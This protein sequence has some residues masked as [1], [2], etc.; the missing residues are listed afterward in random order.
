[1]TMETEKSHSL[2]SASW[3]P[4][5]VDGALLVQS[6]MPKN[7][8]E[9]MVQVQVESKG[10]IIP[11]GRRCKSQLKR[12]EQLCPS[13]TLLFSLVLN[14]FSSVQFISVNWRIP[15][16]VSEDGSSL[17][18]LPTQML[19]SFRNTLTDKLRNSA[20]ESIWVSLAQLSWHV[21]LTAEMSQKYEA[22]VDFVG[23]SSSRVLPAITI[24]KG[25]MALSYIWILRIE[26][27]DPIVEKYQVPPLCSS[28]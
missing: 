2:L 15:I 18:S 3:R 6:Q 1:M 12:R 9:T 8:G 26:P 20:L 24:S 13:S 11:Q 27:L 16:Q 4:R 19:I 23:R 5:K 22:K 10:A 21:K 14:R 28:H 17:L 25:G 7:Q